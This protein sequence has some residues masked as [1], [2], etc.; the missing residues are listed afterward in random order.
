MY[1]LCKRHEKWIIGAINSRKRRRF[2]EDGCDFENRRIFEKVEQCSL[3]SLATTTRKCGVILRFCLAVPVSTTQDELI[4]R[5]S[6]VPRD[7]AT[8]LGHSSDSLTTTRSRVQTIVI[9]KIDEGTFN[10]QLD[11]S[12]LSFLASSDILVSPRHLHERQKQ[13]RRPLETQ[14]RTCDS[15][16]SSKVVVIRDSTTFRLLLHSAGFRAY[17]WGNYLNGIW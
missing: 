15:T 10:F 11:D 7:F 5:G 17:P 4:T 2:T 3:N 12:T 8:V 13:C 14:Q 16:R 6:I 1:F 9:V